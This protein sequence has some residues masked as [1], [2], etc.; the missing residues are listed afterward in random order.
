MKGVFP[1]NVELYLSA[2]IVLL[3]AGCIGAFELYRMPYRKGRVL[4]PANCLLAAVFLGAFLLFYPIYHQDFSDVFKSIL[5]SIHTVMRLFVLD[6]DFEII[7]N[8]VSSEALPAMTATL[9]SGVAATLYVLGPALTF[10]FILSFFKNISAY[11]DFYMHFMS[12]LYVFSEL[13]EKSLALAAS[14]KKHNKH[15]ILVFT[16]VFEQEEETT[17]ELRERARELKAICFKKDI[18]DIKW[19]MSRKTRNVYLFTI[20]EDEAENIEQS[21]KLVSRYSDL[22][23]FR[24]FV[25]S[26][27][28]ESAMLFSSIPGDGIRVRRI[29][30]I[31]S[32]ISLGLYESGD[33][34]F[35]NALDVG[36]SEK[37]IS[38]V[39]LGLGQHGTEMLKALSWFCQMDGYRVEI[40]AFD[41]D[42]LAE[43]RFTAKC[44]E[45][46]DPSKN[47]TDVPGEAHYRI[48]IHSGVDFSAR[49]FQKEFESIEHITFIFVAL[50]DDSSNI[51]TAINM[52]MLSERKGIHPRIQAIVY[53]PHKKEAL[54]KV[55]DYRGH[56][57]DIDFIGDLR[58]SYSRENIVENQLYQVALERHLKWG[59]ENDFWAYEF[60]FNSS[61]AAAIHLR[62]R[63]LCGIPGADKKEGEL[64]QEERDNLEVLEHRRWNAYMRS[65]GFIYSGST[66]KASRN[67]LA[68]IHNDLIPFEGLDEEEKR[69]DSIIGTE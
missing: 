68:K 23:N 25:F 52:R 33:T 2:A 9:Y 26:S 28:A 45:L 14:I 47:G 38:A 41:K 61:V 39:L 10:S 36:G 29:N 57:Y 66:D 42:P 53:A 11:R 58:T 22:Q 67:D 31:R 18:V 20:G 6:G 64:T 40:N 62:M 69:K 7:S 30:P 56:P 59:I 12:D 43:E 51:E 27:S 16:D 13:N 3:I 65:E 32:L 8:F 37:L 46:M 54:E 5:L 1:M 55:T 34:I 24:L 49:R 50:G 15:N 19:D 35:K 21:V 60:N 17:F 4:S 48:N 63:R 44:P